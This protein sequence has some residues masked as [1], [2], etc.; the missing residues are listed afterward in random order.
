MNWTISN[1]PMFEGA[2]VNVCYS[3]IPD[4]WSP[5][6]VDGVIARVLDKDRAVVRFP[7]LMKDEGAESGYRPVTVLEEMRRGQFN[8]YIHQPLA[9]GAGQ[10][11]LLG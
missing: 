11:S 9:E 1:F 7:R 4:C 8:F 10:T 6:F 3:V 5:H 2:V